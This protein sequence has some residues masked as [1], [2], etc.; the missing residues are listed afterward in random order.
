[1]RIETSSRIARFLLA[2]EYYGLG[3]EYIDNY[4]EYINGVTKEDVL[5]VAKKHLDPDNYTLVVVANQEKAA[6][7]EK[8]RQ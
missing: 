4:P 1:M 7:K 6:L 8:F 5:R 2:V 3:I